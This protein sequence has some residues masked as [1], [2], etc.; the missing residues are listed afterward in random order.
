MSLAAKPLS[1]YRVSLRR[2]PES[3]TVSGHLP[4]EE[5]RR[6]LLAI[7]RQRLYR[8]PVIDR[9][10]L[11]EGAPPGL[12]TALEAGA[13][14][15]STLATG[16][17]TV[18]DRTLTVT[19]ESLYPEA[20]ARAPERFSALPAG[21]TGAAAVAPGSR[22]HGETRNPAGKVSPPPPRRRICASPWAARA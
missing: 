4:D 20:A 6:R 18:K 8:E 15:L 1:P 7:L 10:R 5:A 16:E 2:S 12:G 17:A 11:A 14:L 21:W 3:V 22:R 13:G 19:G 9:T